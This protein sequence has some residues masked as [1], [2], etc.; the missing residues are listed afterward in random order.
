MGFEWTC[1]QCTRKYTY[2]GGQTKDAT[3]KCSNKGCTRFRKSTKIW[4]YRVIEREN[5]QENENM[6][7]E[8]PESDSIEIDSTPSKVYN[9][10]RNTPQKVYNTPKNTPKIEL[11]GAMN[12]I[13]TA[14]NYA[15]NTI[16]NKKEV[17]E[18]KVG[19]TYY[20][21]FKRWTS[22]RDYFL[23]LVEIKEKKRLER[24]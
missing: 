10:P 2:K 8:N 3:G 16:R 1:P 12:D 17:K 9:T 4:Q 21:Y 15:I 18:Q 23:R 20:N 24:L 7:K 11:D 5:S 14:F 22:L 13:I 6:R 19:T